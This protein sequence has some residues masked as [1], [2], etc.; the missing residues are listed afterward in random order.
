M[1]PLPPLPHYELTVRVVS[2][3]GR[4]TIIPECDVSRNFAKLLGQKVLTRENIETIKTL[5]FRV[6][7]Q[8]STL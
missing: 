3:Y 6:R 7:T 4:E 8:G 5:G 2:H 1:S